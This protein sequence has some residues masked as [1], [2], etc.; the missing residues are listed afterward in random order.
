MEEEGAI[1]F[2][3]IK[4]FVKGVFR[5]MF[6]IKTIQETIK[7]DVAFTDA[8]IERIELWAK[9]NQGNAPWVDDYVSSLRLEQGICREF[10]NVCL[11]E[12]ETSVSNDKLDEIYQDA[13]QDLNENLQSGLALGSF[14]IKPLGESKVEYVTADRFI[15]VKF[16]SRGRLIDVIFIE[17]KKEKANS[18]YYRFER[19][20][21]DE[22]G[23]LITNKAYHSASNTTIG[24]QVPLSTIDEWANLPEEIYYPG[25]E[26]PDFG[27]Y[28]N[29]IKNNI[30]GSFCGVSIFDSAI[31][32][33]KKTDKQFG[34]LEWEFES[35]E[36][37]IHVDIAAMQSQ[38]TID[39]GRTAWKMP[40]LNKRLY[41][42]LNLQPGANEEL[43]K[44][45]SPEFRDENIINGLNAMLR[46]IEFNTSLSY[47][48]LS[49]A[50]YVEKT[51]T[52]LS[53]AKKRKYNMVTAIQKNLKECLEDLVYALA[54]YNAKL[55][56]G[57]DFVCNFNDS[58]LVD[59]EKEREQDRKDVAM[60][61]LGL[62]EY[63]AKWYNE[64]IEEA[65]SKLPQVADIIL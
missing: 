55:N 42:G 22:I 51:A 46:R 27:Y 24:K 28:R 62:D 65:R 48:D 64:S 33:I 49:D 53:I 37:V 20:K 31:D 35:G 52:E 38:A 32:L 16:D 40:E 15:P 57:Y 45:Y 9:M 10:A 26:K 19:H 12:M 47:G 21:L 17:T 44:E 1:M 36:R 7:E 11:N 6:P 8:M 54:F 3:G 43:Y 56:S 14:I 5:K 41:K 13:I 50:Q 39:G 63:R 25:V 59:E 60:G 18:Y 58:I 61:V 29:P 23:L 4:N 30:D 34:R 2:D